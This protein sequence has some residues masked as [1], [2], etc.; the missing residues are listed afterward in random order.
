MSW[1][2]GTRYEHFLPAVICEKTRHGKL[3]QGR[4]GQVSWGKSLQA[5]EKLDVHPS[6]LGGTE[7]LLKSLLI[8][9]S[10]GLLGRFFNSLFNFAVL[11][12]ASTKLLPLSIC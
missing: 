9:R 4:S 7:R 5:V 8:F 6:T 11:L 12:P 1:R 2:K 10:C 3:W